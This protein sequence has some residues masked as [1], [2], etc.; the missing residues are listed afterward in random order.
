VERARRQKPG[1]GFNAATHKWVSL[2]DEGVIDPLKV[3][4]SSLEHAASASTILLS[5]GAAIVTDDL[6]TDELEEESQ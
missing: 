3:V 1:F 5:V 2:L 6:V 4:R